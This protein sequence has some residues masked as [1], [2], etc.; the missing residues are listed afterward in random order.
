MEKVVLD[1]V[2]E[3]KKREKKRETR[4]KNREDNDEKDRPCKIGFAG[5]LYTKADE[6]LT[7][8]KASI[9]KERQII[10]LFKTIFVNYLKLYVPR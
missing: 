1:G 7:A 6:T 5:R 8:S 10:I 9:I 2:K 4:K 3:R